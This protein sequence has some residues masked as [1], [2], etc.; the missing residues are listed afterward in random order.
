M[1]GTEARPAVV[2]PILVLGVLSFSASAILVRL[3]DAVRLFVSPA[4][5]LPVAQQFNVQTR[6]GVLDLNG[7]ME[8]SGQKAKVAIDRPVASSTTTTTPSAPRTFAP[9]WTTSPRSCPRARRWSSGC[10]GSTRDGPSGRKSTCPG[11]STEG[12]PVWD[13]VESYLQT[14]PVV[15]IEENRSVKVTA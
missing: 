9:W 4:T 11:T 14:T 12:P 13:V 5:L 8:Y 7:R 2:Y 15:H 3:A 1:A 6:H 10:S